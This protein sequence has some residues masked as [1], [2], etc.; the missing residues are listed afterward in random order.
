MSE[1][2]TS[3]YKMCRLSTDIFVEFQLCSVLYCST[4]WI[5]VSYDSLLNCVFKEIYCLRTRN[6]WNWEM[7][8]TKHVR[9]LRDCI[10][11]S[12]HVSICNWEQQNSCSVSVWNREELCFSRFIVSQPNP[13]DLFTTKTCNHIN[14]CSLWTVQTISCWNY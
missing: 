8:L 1:S 14:L 11:G 5:L 10:W 9:F 13:T 12:R 7:N 6:N 3:L 4:L 2:S